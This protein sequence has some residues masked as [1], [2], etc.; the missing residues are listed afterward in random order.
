MKS[1]KRKIILIVV[2]LLLLLFFLL[3]FVW[4][5]RQSYKSVQYSILYHSDT[6]V[7]TKDLERYLAKCCNPIAGE[8]KRNV[9]LP[10]IEA[11]I[12]RWPYCDSVRTFT[13]IHG[14]VRIEMV[15]AK[16]VA[17]VINAGGESFYLAR[18]GSGGKLVP[19]LP[20]RPLR[21]LVVSG[22]IPDRYRADYNMELHD[23]SLC[24]D[25]LTLADYIDSHPFWKAQIT[26]VYVERK[27]MYLLTPL[28]GNHLIT[29]GDVS[30]M[31]EKFDNLWNLY[32]Q[33]LNVVGWYRYAKVNLQFGDK[34]PCEKR[35]M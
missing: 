14:N 26:Q 25:L 35:I 24:R 29:F 27:G 4:S 21:V 11:Q 20:N 32:K 1:R 13:D 10:Q 22:N 18:Q 15:Q 8:L 7:K 2:I 23:T 17:R 6:L 3:Y 31:E 16:V 9:S 28:M 30:R 5:N 34:I 19:F 12:R 33:G